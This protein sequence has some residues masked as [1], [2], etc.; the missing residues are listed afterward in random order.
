MTARHPLRPLTG[1]RV[2]SFEHAV[3]VPYAGRLLAD[4]G[5]DVIKVERPGT[6][7]F[8]RGYDAAC[9][10][11]SSYFAWINRGKRSVVLDLKD[12][13]GLAAA[14]RLVDTAD[15]VLANLGPGATARL[16]LD[17]ETL[18]AR[19]PSLV[20][21]EL[22]GYGEGGPSAG[23]KAYDALIQSEAG[24]LEITG[25]GPVTARAGISVADIA[26]GVQVQS[27]VL[28]ALLHRERT[29]EGATLR[30]TLLEALTEWM[31]Q[32]MLYALGTGTAPTRSGG[33][34]PSIAPY[35][36][37]PCADGAVHLAVQNEREWL[38]LCTVVLGDAAIAVDPRFTTVRTRV[39]HREELHALLHQRFAL[40][41]AE[42][43]GALLDE[44]DIAWS[45]VGHVGELPQHPQLAARG[46]F[47]PV[48]VP[49]GEPVPMTVPPVDSSAWPPPSSPA[50]PAL[51][52]H[53]AEVLAELGYEEKEIAALT[54]GA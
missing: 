6:G 18:R 53:T 44:A 54:A 7:D 23:R 8:A 37:F 9:G 32:P 17:G 5:A 49:G 47:V 4:L 35:G 48:A 30:I 3:S 19:R 29:G 10:D 38:R 20:T 39:Q 16:G 33:H 31:H 42:R 1:T 14:H 40:L 24:L 50:V 22:T 2:V 12:A 51:G 26:A 13:D 45:A 36:P 27:A 34:H 43:L 28:A 41:T 52:A 21:C 46:R 15:V 25:D 11:V